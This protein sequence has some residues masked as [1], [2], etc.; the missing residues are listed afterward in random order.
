MSKVW[1]ITGAST[2]FGRSIAAAASERGHIVVA[3][4]RDR[5]HV[6]EF[7][8]H[9]R[10]DVTDAEQ[11]EQAVTR[12][13]DQH[14]RI[15]VVVN[16]AG[17]GL[18]GVTEEVTDDEL[19]T[20]LETNLLGAW[21]V[22]RSV[23]PHFRR[24][25]SGHFVQMSSV[26][27]VVGNPGHAAYA[28][29][30]FALEGMSEAL[31]G[32]VAGFGIRVTIV[33]PGPFRTDFAGRSLKATDPH[34]AYVGT[35][36]GDLRAG[37]G[38][39]DGRQP[40]DQPWQPTQSLPP[41]KPLSRRYDSPSDPKPSRA[42]APNSRISSRRLTNG[43]LPQPTLGLVDSRPPTGSTDPNRKPPKSDVVRRDALPGTGYTNVLC[44]VCRDSRSC[45]LRSRTKQSWS[46]RMGVTC[47]I[48]IV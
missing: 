35:P 18:V 39:Q 5:D 36:G 27:G 19:R 44:L 25:R 47:N 16:N 20:L 34:P 32:E 7:E 1:F 22:T 21:R 13:V 8:H 37:F 10:L 30:K 17:H 26:G 9:D 11:V 31:A 41:S 4:A 24:Q 29:S 40:N 12:T 38:K 46:P 15:D 23:L 6:A 14:G 48:C 3:T 2:G 33:E 28:S 43:N 45:Q 42:S